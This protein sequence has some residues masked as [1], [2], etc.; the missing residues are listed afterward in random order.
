MKTHICAL[1][2]NHPNRVSKELAAA[3]TLYF[4]GEHPT[5]RK[6]VLD[7]LL[8]LPTDMALNA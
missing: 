5:E 4:N 2:A 3:Y 6:A 7:F 8:L 1:C